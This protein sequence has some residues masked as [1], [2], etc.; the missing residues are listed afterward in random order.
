MKP[1]LTWG[2]S[3]CR[4]ITIKSFK[5]EVVLS[6]LH[7]DSIA[8]PYRDLCLDHCLCIGCLLDAVSHQCQHQ[9]EIPFSLAGQPTL[10]IGN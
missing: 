8:I 10:F 6:Y 5:N 3:C 9:R 7:F 4:A 1:E 2:N